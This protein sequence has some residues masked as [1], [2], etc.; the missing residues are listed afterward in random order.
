MIGLSSVCLLVA[1]DW[2]R[3]VSSCDVVALSI[4]G[5]V[6][7]AQEHGVYVTD[8]QVRCGQCAGTWCIVTDEQVTNLIMP[9]NQPNLS[10]SHNVVCAMACIMVVG[11]DYCI[12]I[13]CR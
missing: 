11:C 3:E 1:I 2:Q 13:L 10:G 8:E 9:H 6:V 4:N 7:S 12:M 5:D